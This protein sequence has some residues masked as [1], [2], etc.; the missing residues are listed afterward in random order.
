[1]PKRRRTPRDKPTL[2]GQL[3]PD[4]DLTWLLHRAAQRM[5]SAVDEQAELHGINLRDY[6]VLTALATFEQVTQLAL[7]EALG[8]DKTTMTLELDRLEQKGLLVRKPDPDDRRA[9]IPEVTA[10]GRSLQA[11]VAAAWTR[12]EGGLL[13][14]F[15]SRDQRALR[16]ML[17]QLIDA[18]PGARIAGSCV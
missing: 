8:L 14:G 6:I 3:S 17:C 1:M 2:V 7:A 15:T 11:K 5:R 12:V 18:G 4:A 13:S 9:R 16:L 10:A